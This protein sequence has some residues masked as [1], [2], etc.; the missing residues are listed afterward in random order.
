MNSGEDPFPGLEVHLWS[1]S[2]AHLGCWGV[3][4]S[5][6]YSEFQTDFLQIAPFS[7]TAAD[8][9]WLIWLQ[10]SFITRVTFIF[11]FGRELASLSSSSLVSQPELWCQTV[12]ATISLPRLKVYVCRACG[13]G[14]WWG[15]ETGGEFMQVVG[16]MV[17]RK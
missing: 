6:A 17:I 2:P 15:R 3:C 11:G 12:Q 16:P 9:L 10:L 14:E 1:M 13:E 5:T 7:L 4:G 8:L